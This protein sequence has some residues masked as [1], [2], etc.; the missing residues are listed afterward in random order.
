MS[1]DMDIF[2]TSATKALSKV[3]IHVKG[4]GERVYIKLGGGNSETNTVL[5]IQFK[6]K[7]LIAF[8]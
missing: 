5:S 3:F 6:Y 4:N 1:L 7:F 2:S 8:R